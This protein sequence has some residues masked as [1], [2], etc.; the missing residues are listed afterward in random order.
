VGSLLVWALLYGPA[1][2]DT[3]SGLKHV[4]IHRLHLG[5]GLVDLGFYGGEVWIDRL[6]AFEKRKGYGTKLVNLA[7]DHAR[8]L[9]IKEVF[10]YSLPTE[11]AQAFWRTFGF[12]GDGDTLHKLTLGD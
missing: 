6:K 1:N 5:C 8:E 2:T 10:L 9:G 11:E 4:W 7:L 3:P 12:H